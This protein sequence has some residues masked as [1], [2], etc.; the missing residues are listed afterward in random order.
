MKNKNQIRFWHFFFFCFLLQN[1]DSNANV[2]FFTIVYIFFY[3]IPRCN[4][5]VHSY[6]SITLYLVFVFSVSLNSYSK[7]NI[8]RR[9]NNMKRIHWSLSGITVHCVCDCLFSKKKKKFLHFI[10]GLWYHFVFPD[11]CFPSNLESYWILGSCA[12][13]HPKRIIP[14]YLTAISS[15][16]Y[17]NTVSQCI[18]REMADQ[19]LQ[20]P[21]SYQI[22]LLPPSFFLRFAMVCRR[23]FPTTYLLVSKKNKKWIDSN[24]G[25]IF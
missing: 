23:A 3:T 13:A 10:Y 4:I 20:L 1:F 25:I 8:K 9:S 6:C 18:C 5:I 14:I 11:F 24:V 19:S 16:F 15:T 2:S 12:R 17:Q 22:S 21:L 7:L